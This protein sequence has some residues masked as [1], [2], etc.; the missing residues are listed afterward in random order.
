MSELKTKL[1]QDYIVL[2]LFLFAFFLQ[3]L[4]WFFN[5]K[6][7]KTDFTITP[8]PPSKLEKAFF[9]FGDSQILYRFYGM[10]LQNAGDTFGEVTPLQDYDYEKLEKWFFALSELDEKSDYVPS[11]AGFYFSQSQSPKDNKYVVS[12]LVKHAEQDPENKWRWFNDAAYIA[13]YKLNDLP[14]AVSIASKVLKLKNP[15]IPLWA[16]AMAIFVSKASDDQCKTLELAAEFLGSGLADKMMEDKVFGAQGGQHNM[17]LQI[18]KKNVESVQKDP[19]IL[20]DCLKK[21]ERES[22]KK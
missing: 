15:D 11:L 4:L 14:L 17:L 19:K 16:R 21:R 20:S 1:R 6:N 5:T 10:E 7:I 13:R 2:T 8:F 3:F 9:S 12:Y 22:K 18:L